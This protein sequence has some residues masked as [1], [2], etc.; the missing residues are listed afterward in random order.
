[1]NEEYIRYW[2]LTQH[3]FLLAPDGR[4]MCV[5]GQYFECLER[6]R[7][8]VSTNKGGALIVSEEAGLGKTTTLLRLIDEMREEHGTNF[9]F[10]Y[11]DHPTLTANQLIEE[12]T[13]FITG[14]MPSGDKLKN[15]QRLKACLIQAKREGGKSI[16]AIDEGQMLCDSPEVLQELRVLINLTHN[17]EYL[18]TFVLSGQKA[19]WETLQ[20]IPEFWQRLPVRYYFTPLRFEETRELVRYRLNR[21]GLDV[22]REIFTDEAIEAIHRQSKGLPRTIIAISDL[23]LLNGFTDKSRKI[24]FKEVSKAIGAMNGKG[25]SLSYVMQDRI[26]DRREAPIKPSDEEP[27]RSP[28]E[29][30]GS[31]AVNLKSHRY[32][33]PVIMAA[34]VIALILLGALGQ[35][36]LSPSKAVVDTVPAASKTSESKTVSPA[37]VPPTPENKPQQVNPI[38]TAETPSSGMGINVPKEGAPAQKAESQP[39]YVRAAIVNINGATIRSAPYSDSQRIVTIYKGEML[40]IED[41]A[42]DHSGMKWYKVLLYNDREGWISDKV[43]VVTTIKQ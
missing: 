10:A 8:A 22:A 4:M 20:G 9:R 39:K 33:R 37:V 27:M 23:A 24:T 36:I 38:D 28:A 12:I 7:Y 13:G 21:A 30:I 41:E 17:N 31:V 6:L 26:D 19:L 3:P 40:P 35:K 15:L 25:D 14:E 32:T 5:T 2:G 34:A 18:H 11:I 29:I 42:T 43:V 16:I 1:M